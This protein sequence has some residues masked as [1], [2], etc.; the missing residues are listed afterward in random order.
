MEACEDSSDCE[1]GLTCAD[2]G[3][4]AGLCTKR[5]SSHDQCRSET[6]SDAMF[7]QTLNVFFC[8]Q[9]CDGNQDCPTN[10]C[11]Q[12]SNGGLYCIP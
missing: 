9:S 7:C 12:G 8:A 10:H 11:K 3:D 4:I 2:K 1:E 6:G 5:C